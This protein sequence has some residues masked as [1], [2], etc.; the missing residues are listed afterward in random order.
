M[1]PSFLFLQ[2]PPK[3]DDFF[4]LLQEDSCWSN[5]LDC[6]TVTYPQRSTQFITLK[7][8]YQP[9]T[10]NLWSHSAICRKANEECYS[11]IRQTAFL[12]QQNIKVTDTNLYAR[13]MQIQSRSTSFTSSATHSHLLPLLSLKFPVLNRFWGPPTAN[14]TLHIKTMKKLKQLVC[15]RLLNSYRINYCLCLAKAL[16]KKITKAKIL[17]KYPFRYYAKQSSLA[18]Y[19]RAKKNLNM[20]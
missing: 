2:A 17:S 7:R 11:N 10:I 14:V 6:T 16:G 5:I 4:Q 3:S 18:W 12:T 15:I 13:G 20:T 1:G 8:S 19:K 9:K